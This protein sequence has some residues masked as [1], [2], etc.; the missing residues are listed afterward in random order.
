MYAFRCC[1]AKIDSRFRLYCSTIHPYK[2]N[3]ECRH[4]PFYMVY[5]QFAMNI[6]RKI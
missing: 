1:D 3:S 2:N 5:H 4:L 6:G